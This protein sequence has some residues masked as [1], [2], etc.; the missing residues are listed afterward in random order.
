MAPGPVS[1]SKQCAM[2][3]LIVGQN[4][5]A[6]LTGAE[7]QT[8]PQQKQNPGQKVKVER[9]KGVDNGSS[10]TFADA[11]Q[12][13]KI[14]T[15]SACSRAC[16]IFFSTYVRAA[17]THSHSHSDTTRSRAGPSWKYNIF[18]RPTA[19]SCSIMFICSRLCCGRDNLCSPHYVRIGSRI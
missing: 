17:L 5:T 6:P 15:C 1:P 3:G 18:H 11:A 7:T 14:Y 19:D 12:K 16:S 2:L 9:C 13:P 8:N 10:L 4:V